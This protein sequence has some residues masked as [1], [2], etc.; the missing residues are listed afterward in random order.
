M[1]MN[2]QKT[3]R[4]IA[5]RLPRLARRDVAEVLEVM[6]ELWIAE[7]SQPGTTVTV[8]DLGKLVVEVQSLRS[9]GA[10]Q[11]KMQTQHGSAAPKT[12]KRIYVRTEI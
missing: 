7:L 9:G 2:H 12:L 10:V 1:G 5:R 6:A 4:E 8:S 3:V 11:R